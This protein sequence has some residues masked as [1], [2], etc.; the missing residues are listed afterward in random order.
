MS[1]TPASQYPTLRV[2]QCILSLDYFVANVA[3]VC[4]SPR[5]VGSRGFVSVVVYTNAKV[6][7]LTELHTTSG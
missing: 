5:V 2:S 1:Y 6:A 7:Q 3:G 4:V